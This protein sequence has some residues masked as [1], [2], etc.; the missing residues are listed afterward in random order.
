MKRKNF[1][2]RL[3]G[4]VTNIKHAFNSSVRDIEKQVKIIATNKHINYY[5]TD[6]SIDRETLSGH[7]TWK[8][9]NGDILN[10]RISQI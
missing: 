1:E 4:K 8:S 2:I 7:R 5:L 9:D 3:N 10:F 6:A